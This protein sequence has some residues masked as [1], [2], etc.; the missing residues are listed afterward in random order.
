MAEPVFDKD[1]F[2]E[3]VNSMP[4]QARWKEAAVFGA[5]NGKDPR[6]LPFAQALINVRSSYYALKCPCVLFLGL[7]EGSLSPRIKAEQSIN[8]HHCRFQLHS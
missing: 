4:Y 6:F 5:K 2:L 7:G 1:A 8:D 3:R